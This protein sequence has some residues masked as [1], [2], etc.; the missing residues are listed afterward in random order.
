VPTDAKANGPFFIEVLAYLALREHGA[1]AEEVATAF[2]YYL[3]TIRNLV[4]VVRDRLGINPRTGERHLPEA[5]KSRAAQL[6]GPPV[7]QVDDL[8]VDIDLFGRLRLRGQARTDHGI[9]DLVTALRL[10]TGRPFSQLRTGGWSWLSDLN[11]DHHMVCAIVDVA[12]YLS[13]WFPAAGDIRRA[14]A[15]SQTALR[16]A[17]TTPCPSSISPSSP[18]P[19]VTSSWPDRS[20]TT[21]ATSPMKT[22][23]PVN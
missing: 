6:R 13:S 12:H 21:Y 1:T 8:L 22:G 7:Y 10:V 23:S 9:A 5:S 18:K 19:K 20:P 14:R 11:I 3:S 2:G 17:P 15:A 4:K 16:A